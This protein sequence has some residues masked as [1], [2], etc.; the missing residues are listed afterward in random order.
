MLVI[1]VANLKPEEV[2]LAID[3]AAAEG[4]NPGLDDARAFAAADPTGFFVGRVDGVPTATISVV[5]YGRTFAFLGLYIVKPGERGK[6]YGY[7]LWQ[8]A[9]A[10][11][12]GRNVG[13]DGVVAQQEC[14]RRSG[15]ALA[16]RNLRYRGVRGAAAPLDA[17]VVPLSS[18]PIAEVIAYD[19]AFFPEERSAFLRAWLAQPHARGLAALRDGRIAGYGVLRKC[20]QGYKVGPLFADDASLAEALFQALS[21][22]APEGTELFLDVPE[23]N[24]AGA[25]LAERH[26]MGVVFETARMYTGS[27]PKLPLARLFGV[28]TFELG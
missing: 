24:R 23:H 12:A 6:G 10:T 9:L 17:R 15:F 7:A 3:W 5:K 18:L 19:R 4:W 2:A 25:A 13:L 27:A 16:Y 20:R 8:A 26:G 1:E 11:A 22:Y 14:Y 28:T 21:M